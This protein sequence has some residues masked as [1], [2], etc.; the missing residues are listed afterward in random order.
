M[1][2][3][4]ISGFYCNDYEPKKIKSIVDEIFKSLSVNSEIIKPNSKVLIKPNLLSAYTPEQAI[5]THPELVRAV[6]KK[7]KELKAIPIIGDSAG[8]LLRGMEYVWEKTGMLQV[9]KEEGAELIN[10]ETVGSVELTVEH[11]TMKNIYLTKALINCDYIINIPKIKTHT[12]Y[13]KI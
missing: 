4:I 3:T 10:F 12:F 5:T 13:E 8:N 7:I 9:A 11:P 6:V 1:A 2:R